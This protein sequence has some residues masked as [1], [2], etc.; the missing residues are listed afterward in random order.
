[1][2][3][4]LLIVSSLTVILVAA[5]LLLFSMYS[6]DRVAEDKDK[7]F[8]SG[9][10]DSWLATY[11]VT[12]AKSSLYNSLTIQYLFDPEISESEA[13]KI[14]PIEYQLDTSSM[15]IESSSPQELQGVGSFH[16][17][18][19]MNADIFSLTLEETVHLTVSWQGRTEKLVL[20]VQ[21]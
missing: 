5:V 3:K 8:Y 1:M 21:K 20:E 19:R 4:V 16:T 7:Q 17:G 12:N 13:G 2:K 18:S 10:S 14:G 9:Q 11:S 6:N 15:K